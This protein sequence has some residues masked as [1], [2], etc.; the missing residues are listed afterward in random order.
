MSPSRITTLGKL[1]GG[2]ADSG[3]GGSF[4]EIYMSFDKDGNIQDIEYTK[5]EQFNKTIAW[6]YSTLDYSFPNLK[7]AR[8][9]FKSSTLWVIG[10]LNDEDA[11]NKYYYYSLPELV[12]GNSMFYG[13]SSIGYSWNGEVKKLVL[14]LPKLSNGTNMFYNVFSSTYWGAS[15]TLE[16]LGNK[17]EIGSSMFESCSYLR[18]LY[19]DLSSLT[20][21][22]KMF[23]SASYNSTRLNLASVQN[24]ADTINDLASQ[25]KTGTIDIGMT[26]SLKSDDETAPI[27]VALATIRAK[28][29][30]VTEIYR[31]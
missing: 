24:I 30:T 11:A 6:P 20:N 4:P 22:S 2:G 29:W 31:S 21:G 8:N 25:G 27:N 14:H 12:D 5:I 3:G 16:I 19:I 9:M 26:S 23:G 15:N 17:L 13:C 28:G 18:T 10:S 7:S 1:N